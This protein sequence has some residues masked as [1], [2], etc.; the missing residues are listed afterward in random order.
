MDE[1]CQL[2][3]RPHAKF[4]TS[5]KNLGLLRSTGPDVADFQHEC[6]TQRSFEGID[7]GLPDEIR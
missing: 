4:N 5:R 7:Q 6:L 3:E 1:W 2:S